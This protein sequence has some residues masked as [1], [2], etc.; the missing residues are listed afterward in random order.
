[1]HVA[2]RGDHHKFD[3]GLVLDPEVGGCNAFPV[4]TCIPCIRLE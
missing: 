4:S 3:N 2:Q 1:M